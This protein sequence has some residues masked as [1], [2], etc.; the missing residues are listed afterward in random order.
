[1]ADDAS[2]TGVI[3]ATVLIVVLVV[4]VAAVIIVLLL[5]NGGTKNIGQVII[6][7][8]CSTPAMLHRKSVRFNTVL[9]G[10]STPNNLDGPVAAQMPNYGGLDESDNWAK[11]QDKAPSGEIMNA[12]DAIDKKWDPAKNF[13]TRQA[14]QRPQ[15][16]LGAQFG[17]SELELQMFL[18]TQQELLAC[19]AQVS[20]PKYLRRGPRFKRGND[21]RPLMI[22]EGYKDDATVHRGNRARID[23][24]YFAEAIELDR[25]FHCNSGIVAANANGCR[26][27]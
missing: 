10:G 17:P 6:N 1:M 2:N 20:G 25:K 12:P 7:G 9:T 24:S 21:W 4:A 3:V 13:P 15:N 16:S 18:P 26:R 23:E 14:P 27:C 5:Q 22:P 8:A 19:Q 11:L